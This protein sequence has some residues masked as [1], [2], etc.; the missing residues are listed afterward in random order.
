M[1]SKYCRPSDIIT[2]SAT[3]ALTS[4]SANSAFPLANLYDRK[5]HTVFKSTGTGCTIRATFLTAKTLQ[6][7]ALINHKL[8]GATVVLSNGA[9]LSQAVTI[10]SNSEDGHCIDP[11]KTLI[12]V[13]NASSTTWDLTIT[14]AATVVAIGELLLVQTLR[15]FNFDRE[16]D[17]AETHASIVQPT[18]YG[19]RRK[20]SMATRQRSKRGTVLASQTVRA[21]VIALQR[22][23]RGPL[24][25]FLLVPNESA[26]DALFVDLTVSER[27][28][29]RHGPFASS[30]DLEF[31]EQ[32][33]GL[34][35]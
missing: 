21:D 17:E 15:T 19:V 25:N 29:V 26:N 27:R 24:K 20:Y 10:P 34:A 22:D 14:G 16:S 7:V 12:G 5:A 31:T 35:L 4:G 3:I 18:D 13:A 11:W 33:K 28:L 2:D 1:A 8:A 6:A 30:V 32:Q 9:G 23:A